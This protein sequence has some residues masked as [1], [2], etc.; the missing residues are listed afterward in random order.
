MEFPQRGDLMAGG[1]IE[2]V[3]LILIITL[4]I[5]LRKRF[6][7]L[8]L[9]LGIGTIVYLSAIFIIGWIGIILPLK[10][11][12]WGYPV[13]LVIFIIYHVASNLNIRSGYSRPLGGL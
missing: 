13:M 5:V 9:D 4:A 3:A 8:L 1:L 10:V 11:A 2:G 12:E 7:A 6:F